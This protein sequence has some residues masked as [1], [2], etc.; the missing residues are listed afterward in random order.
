MRYL[1]NGTW[2]QKADEDTIQR[3]GIPSLVLMERA[4]LKTV[5]V[6]KER[7]IAL[8]QCLVVCGS[9]NNGGD[10]F[11]VARLL[12][13]EGKRV[14]A[15]FVGSEASMS[16]EC[17]MQREIAGNLGVQIVTDIPRE[18][19]TVVIDAV[20][21][22]GL[23]RPVTGRYAEVIKA[24]NQK[25]GQKVAVDVPSGISSFDGSVLGVAFRADLTVSFA[26][27]KLG[28]VLFP[29]YEY[30]GEV[31]P[32][33]IGIATDIF[34][35]QWDI[36]YTLDREDLFEMLPKRKKNSHKGSYGKILMITGSKGMSGAAYLSAKSAYI[37]GCGLVQIYTEETNR[38]ILQQ[39]LPEAIV[40]TYTVY[41]EEALAALLKWADV[42]CIGCG[43][44]KSKVSEQILEYVLR[45]LEIPC[46]IDADGLNLL[47]RKKELLLQEAKEI[48]L[49][50]HMKEMAGM[51]GCTVSE[52]AERRFEKLQKFVGDY[53]VVCALKD[54][55]TLVAAQGRQMFLN[56]AG[57]SAMA[58]AGSGDVLAG[59][60]AGLLAQHMSAY[61]AAVLGVYLHACGG[62]EARKRC[63]A[64][65]VLAQD[66]TEGIKICIKETKRGEN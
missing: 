55:R 6:M 22:V 66:L 47:A 28:S 52:L 18:E 17:R 3:I 12:H 16:E 65:S 50:P 23:S 34:R 46:V 35:K 63:G 48:I 62:D 57:N 56:T 53:G 25:K 54:A 32:A 29:G 10:G 44:G 26:C 13:M 39:L 45:H 51:I 41:E 8:E 36:C 5:E 58:K 31:V 24:M 1:P 43:L 19:Y 40:S 30:S 38:V 9:G 7:Q 42:V 60:I 21:G 20:F 2:M 14:C 59:V 4:A 64:Y 49:T 27:E 15:V 61:D 37:S 33:E 11:A